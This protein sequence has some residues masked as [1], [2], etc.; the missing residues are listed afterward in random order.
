M[1]PHGRARVSPRNPRAFA[2][3]DRC[4]FL[5]N[6]VNQQWQFDWRGSTLQ[7]LRF[8]VCRRCLDTPQ[9]QLRAITVPADPTPIINARVENYAEYESDTF[10]VDTPVVYDPVINIPVPPGLNITGQNGNNLTPQPFG[11]PNGLVQGAVMPLYGKKHYAVPVPVLS[12]SANGT[13]TVTVTCSKAHDLVTN[14]QI[15]VE[16]L[17]NNLADG[18]FSVTVTT[19][20]A[21]TYDTYSVIAA[22]ALLT[23]TSRIITALVGLPYGYTQI[24]QTGP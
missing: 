11:Q 20:T 24:P 23:G 18:F 4:G 3:C 13:N 15:S 10:A 19:A 12:V 6:H 5:Y 1:R 9:Q 17:T 16:G 14:D 22:G 8:L 2:V 21:F 7:N